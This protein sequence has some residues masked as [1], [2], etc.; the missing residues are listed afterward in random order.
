LK[1]SV[2]VALLLISAFQATPAV[3]TVW[4]GVYTEEQAV[5]GEEN[6]MKHCIECH[7]GSADGPILSGD[8]FANRW[9]EDSIN[10]LFSYMRT[11]MPEDHP[12]TL[13]EATYL[14]TLAYVLWQNEFP[15]GA[16]EL[17]IAALDNIQF[18]G[19][20]GPKPLS[21]GTLVYSLGCLTQS[22]DQWAL[23][24]APSP[25]RARNLQETPE[26]FKALESQPLGNL[27]VRLTNMAM[28]RQTFDPAQYRDQKVYAKG[29]FGY[30]AG[31]YSIDLI[32]LRPLSSSCKTFVGK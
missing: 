24:N 25:K 19:I 23:N 17:K 5:R 18:V 10:A 12:G 31:Q 14:D 21:N 7:D 3:K 8:E 1:I 6:F 15:V 4:D 20:D 2:C 28:M 32:A 29:L 22:G 9:R 16:T 13:S 27:S 26:G 11:K 30:E